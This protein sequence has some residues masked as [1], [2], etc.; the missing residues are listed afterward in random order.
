MKRT[1]SLLASVLCLA[2][3]APSMVRAEYPDRP[4]RIVSPFSP[5]GGLDVVARLIAPKLSETYK[6]PVLVE[7]RTGANGM[8]AIEHVSKSPAD[9]YTLLIE[10]LGVSIHPAV[11]KNPPYDPIKGLEPVA[12]LASLPFIVIA[13][14]KLEV[15]SLRELVEHAKKNP[16]KLNFAQGGMTNRILGELLRLETGVEFTF[17]PYKGSSPATQ[18]VM[19]GESDLTVMDPLTA[20]PQVT[21]GR[22]RALGVT[23]QKRSAMLP[24][25]PTIA[26]AGLPQASAIVWYGIFAPGGTPQAVV[27]RLNAEL[28]RIVML[29]DVAARLAA[30]GAEPVN[31]T[32]E[33]FG[34]L[35]RRQMVTWKDVATRAKIPVE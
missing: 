33:A 24:D 14:P 3:T 34:D 17:I 25:V 28:N 7:N 13:N 15:R 1:A 12:H 31:A 23:G 16:G 4:T 9:G 26:E 30:V 21:S 19:T 18:A 20:T 5:G 27:R 32:P 8:I 10:T 11:V 22:L 6:Q 2:L 35:F 29:P